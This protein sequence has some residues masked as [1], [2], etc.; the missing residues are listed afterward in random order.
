MTNPS[1]EKEPVY[2]TD[3]ESIHLLTTI[4]RE[5]KPQ[6]RERDLAMVILFLHT[7]VRNGLGQPTTLLVENKNYGLLSPINTSGNL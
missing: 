2:L 5:A 6:V 1:K 3:E 7:G 4:A